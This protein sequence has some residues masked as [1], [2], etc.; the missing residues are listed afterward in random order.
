MYTYNTNH[1]NHSALQAVMRNLMKTYDET[2]ARTILVEKYPE[3]EGEVLTLDMNTPI[4]F[5]TKTPVN[6]SIE[7]IDDMYDE[8]AEIDVTEIK[9]ETP[10]EEDATEESEN[11]NESVSETIPEMVT[12]SEPRT[13]S[14][15]KK[16][17]TVKEPSKAV[18]AM[19]L[20][21]SAEDK[22]RSHMMEV[23]M[24]ELGMTKNG[25]STYYYNCKTKID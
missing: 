24:T 7:E 17:K 20:Y 4:P 19:E 11:L 18:R 13:T 16:E 3:L 10:S 9:T 23:F 25:A 21:S 1:L 22:S 6:I 14:K 8:D 12:V 5:V 15:A 2:A